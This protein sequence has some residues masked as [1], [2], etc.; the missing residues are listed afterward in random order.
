MINPI[1][2]VYYQD[3]CK[4]VKRLFAGRGLKQRDET[5]AGTAGREPGCF[6]R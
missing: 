5:P 3:K 1:D 4:S 6:G 2:N